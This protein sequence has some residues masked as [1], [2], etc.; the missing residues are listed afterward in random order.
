MSS[1]A[2][3]T[4]STNRAAALRY[5]QEHGAELWERVRPWYESR[6]REEI[7]RAGQSVRIPAGPM[8]TTSQ[9]LD[10]PQL[11]ARG[12]FSSA[13]VDGVALRV[14]RVPYR[15]RAA[16]PLMRGDPVEPDRAVFEPGPWNEDA[17]IQQR[18]ANA[19]Y[20]WYSSTADLPPKT[21]PAVA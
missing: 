19:Q 9:R 6:T 20:G 8:D 1:L 13:T 18:S 2:W 16:A 3:P 21:D 17:G 4:P 15:L 12:F 14:P 11:V 5:R 10:D 7:T